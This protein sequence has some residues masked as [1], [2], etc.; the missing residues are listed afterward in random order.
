MVL[1][2]ITGTQ[3]QKE[4]KM[5]AHKVAFCMLALLLIAIAACLPLFFG[6]AGCGSDSGFTTGERTV[7][8]GGIERVYYLKLP[9]NYNSYTAYPLIF[10]FHGYTGDYTNWTE[11]YDLQEV[12]GDEAIL[13]YP[14][15]LLQNDW[16]QWNYETDPYFFDDLYAELEKNI[17]FDERKV[18]A[19]GHSNGA[20]MAH[21]LGWKRGN[22]LR[23]IGPVAG[24]LTNTKDNSGQVAVIQIHGSADTDKTI[25]ASRPT[26]DYWIAINSCNKEETQEGVDPICDAY[27][28]C[29]S[30]FPVQYCVHSGTHDWPDSASEA[31]WDFF[32]SLPDAV[33]SEKT[34][35]VDVENLGKGTISFKV[36][37]PSD[38]VGT[39][40]MVGV[41]L[42]PYNS[43]QPFAGGPLYM[44]TLDA[45]VGDYTFGEVTEYDDVELDLLGVEYGDYTLAVVVYIEGG[46][47]PRPGNGE[48][49][50]G[51]QN[52]TLDS[53]T[54]TV[55][56]PF[57]LELFV[58]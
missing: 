24:T 16:S 13:V 28:G 17:C 45:S 58:Y 4:D 1:L 31:I 27:S 33:P 40:Y 54:L 5:K 57:E 47:Y 41:I 12:V 35:D 52:F 6:S 18:F 30:D 34:S 22:I 48:D 42:Y 37:Y 38:F 3:Q 49:Y 20:G 46:S 7:T 19:V 51:L 50:I 39:P 14:N 44:L 26:R 43:S 56:T 11:G 36:D 10:A 32:K 2:L 25:E 29:D 55:E 9:E 8:S 53:D 21:T 23:A 15:A